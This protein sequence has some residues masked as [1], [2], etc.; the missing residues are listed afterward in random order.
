MQVKCRAQTEVLGRPSFAGRFER[1]DSFTPPESFEGHLPGSSSTVLSSDDPDGSPNGHASLPQVTLTPTAGK[2]P[3]RGHHAPAVIIVKVCRTPST[4]SFDEMPKTGL[5]RAVAK[6]ADAALS[7][8]DASGFHTRVVR[9]EA[10]LLRFLQMMARREGRGDTPTSVV[11]LLAD[12][13]IRTGVD[14]S[15]VVDQSELPPEE[16]SGPVPRLLLF[17]RMVDL[18][19]VMTPD[20][21]SKKHRQWT[22][23][24]VEEVARDIAAGL[25]FLHRNHSEYRSTLFPS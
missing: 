23:N 8:G 5:G 12:L 21:W 6:A 25:S 24:E 15:T 4:G 2:V 16:H 3:D 9:G 19:A 10:R 7:Q 20:G 13:P 22:H 17:E 11:R 14:G 1:D 18:D